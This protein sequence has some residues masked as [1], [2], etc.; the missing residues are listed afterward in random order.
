MWTLNVF[1]VTID[2]SHSAYGIDWIH[3]DSRSWSN[4]RTGLHSSGKKGSGQKVSVL[5][6]F[7]PYSVLFQHCNH[8]LAH[9]MVKQFS[10][11][12]GLARVPVTLP[13]FCKPFLSKKKN[14]RRWQKWH[15]NLLGGI[16]AMP[17]MNIFY[18]SVDNPGH[19]VHVFMVKSHT[20]TLV[21]TECSSFIKYL[22]YGF[23][24]YS[25]K[26][27]ISP[28]SFWENNALQLANQ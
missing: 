21:K 15:D 4:W 3:A 16:L 13:P 7:S 17:L 9:L 20:K 22:L 11:N 25:C 27:I 1:I 8:D 19:L 2:S 18:Y 23:F 14:Y 12:R 5:L 6:Q 10:I 28:Q 26:P 24:V